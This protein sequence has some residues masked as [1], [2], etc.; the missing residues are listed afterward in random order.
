MTRPRVEPWASRIVADR[1]DHRAIEA[2]E[3]SRSCLREFYDLYPA[4]SYASFLLVVHSH[5]DSTLS[6]NIHFSK[7][8][9]VF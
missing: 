1:F 8:M 6:G 4:L 3:I 5:V 9:L 2:M 7:S